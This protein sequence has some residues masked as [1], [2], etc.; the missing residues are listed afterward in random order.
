VWKR[1]VTG[2]K[3]QLLTP[4]QRKQLCVISDFRRGV[5]KIFALLGCYKAYTGSYRRFGTYRSHLQGSVGDRMSR[6]VDNYLPNLLCVTSQNSEDLKQDFR[7]SI[8]IL[9]VSQYQNNFLEG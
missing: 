4:V 1:G 9:K 2:E 5:A 6:N 8:S 3:C 7:I